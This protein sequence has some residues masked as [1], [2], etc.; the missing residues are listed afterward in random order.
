M[1]AKA[2]EALDRVEDPRDIL[3]Y[4]YQQQV[5]MLTKTQRCIADFAVSRAAVELQMKKL[6]QEQALQRKA[7][8]D[9][10]LSSLAVHHNSLREQ[11]EL[12]TA[13]CEHLTSKIE[14]FRVRIKTVK[15]SYAAKA[16]QSTAAA[17]QGI[18]GETDNAG[19]TA[20][21]RSRRLA[22]LDQ[23]RLSS[24]E[25][26]ESRERLVQQV[27]SFRQQWAEQ[28]G[29]AGQ[30]VA[31]GQK[32]QAQHLS[33]RKA[34]VD[35]HLS[36][37]V[38]QCHS[39][40][41]AEDIAASVCKRIAATVEAVQPQRE[42][43]RGTDASGEIQRPAEEQDP[44]VPE[45]IGTG[46]IPERSSPIRGEAPHDAT[47]ERSAKGTGFWRR[48]VVPEP[49]LD[50][51]LAL[52]SATGVLAEISGFTPTGVCSIC[53]RTA[54][55]NAFSGIQRNVRGWLERDE[56][57]APLVAITEDS[58]GF[59]WMVIRW[60]PDRFQA[61]IRR[62]YTAGSMFGESGFGAQL[63]CSVTPFHDKDERNIALVYL[64]Q[65]GTFYPFAPQPEESRNNQLEL[66]IRDAIGGTLPLEPDLR[67]W[68]PVWNAPG[69]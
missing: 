20:V 26:S 21:S 35:R 10:E 2:E 3:D 13:A 36:D 54:E 14:T 15:D 64:Y 63:L 7:Q 46:D 49:I 62:A 68:Y 18:S 30:A 28:E 51:L 17:S 58:Y 23:L 12:L 38:A 24:D 29:S 59:A 47:D 43:V 61:L 1:K 8:V 19:L 39:A 65:Y 31:S 53:F 67:R 52:A 69:L 37:L 11:E 41:E 34:E 56:D 5:E 9:G 66:T 27:N 60:A 4:S 45:P 44:G 25:M 33:V 50:P 40:Q 22:M 16:Q 55:T 42:A 32:D 57:N 48:R 6:C